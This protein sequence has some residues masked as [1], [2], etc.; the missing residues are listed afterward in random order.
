MTKIPPTPPKRRRMYQHLAIVTHVLTPEMTY[1]VWSAADGGRTNCT[2]VPEGRSV[3]TSRS[4]WGHPLSRQSRR[5]TSQI[6]FSRQHSIPL[7]WP[8]GES[9]PQWLPS[10]EV[11]L[12]CQTSAYILASPANPCMSSDEIGKEVSRFHWR[13]QFASEI[14]VFPCQ[15]HVFSPT[16]PVHP[17]RSLRK[18]LL[19]SA[20]L[21]RH[22]Q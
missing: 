6:V 10:Q 14:P 9:C 8:A 21:R 7:S 2:R 22:R 1:R 4:L 16:P 15:W 18:G 20:V 13:F 11:V 19:L 17:L 3:K 5:D 12:A